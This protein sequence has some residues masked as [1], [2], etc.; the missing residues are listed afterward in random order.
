[1]KAGAFTPATL[2]DLV[3]PQALDVV[4]SMKAG[5]FTPATQDRVDDMAGTDSHAQ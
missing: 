3:V 5:A 4:R 2:R 1:M